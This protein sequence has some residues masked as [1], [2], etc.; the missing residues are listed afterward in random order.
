VGCRCIHCWLGVLVWGGGWKNDPLYP[1]CVWGCGWL[2]SHCFLGIVVGLS[3]PACFLSRK[4]IHW[5][6]WGFGI[7]L[8]TAWGSIHLKIH[9]VGC[10][11]GCGWGWFSL[12]RGVEISRCCLL[13]VWPGSC[14]L[15]A[16]VGMLGSHWVGGSWGGWA[17]PWRNSPVGGLLGGGGCFLAGG[18]VV[19]V[20]LVFWAEILRIH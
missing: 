8:V 1:L 12:W 18:F 19:A 5:D 14:F 2:E 11:L 6:C 4:M 16:C 9:W 3:C 15:G 17:P 7:P 20:P 13:L 10:W